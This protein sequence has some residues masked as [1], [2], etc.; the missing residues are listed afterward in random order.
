MKA[1]FTFLLVFIVFTGFS[2]KEKI[3]ENWK[4]KVFNDLQRGHYAFIQSDN[5]LISCSNL[6]NNFKAILEPCRQT[7]Q[8]TNFNNNTY[9]FQLLSIEKGLW[10][11]PVNDFCAYVS[12]GNK[13]LEKHSQFD[14]EYINT[15]KGLK[16]N[17][18]VKNK[19]QCASFLKVQLQVSGAN[20]SIKLYNN[21]II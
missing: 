2:Q 18:I 7:I 16:Q 14:L 10:H 4:R 11:A 17:F 13:I 20:V 9:S 1:G 15:Q 6:N 19:I 8:L 21:E 12:T 3:D 5:N